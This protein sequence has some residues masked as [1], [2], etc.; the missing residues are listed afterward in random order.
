MSQK[1]KESIKNFQST[2]TNDIIIIGGQQLQKKE[3]AKESNI[4]CHKL[5]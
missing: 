2:T 5:E 4:P 1:Q 3:K